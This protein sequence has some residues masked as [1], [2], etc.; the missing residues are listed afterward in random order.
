MPVAHRNPADSKISI[1]PPP[2]KTRPFGQ[3]AQSW[4]LAVATDSK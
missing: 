2:W 3:D 4:Q 1:F